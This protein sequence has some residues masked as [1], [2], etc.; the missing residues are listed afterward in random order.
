LLSLIE[1]R[2]QQGVLP[3]KFFG[4][5]HSRSIPS[6]PSFVTL[7][8]LRALTTGQDVERDVQDVVGLVVGQMPLE[9]VDLRVDRADQ[10]GLAGQE[11]YGADSASGETLD[12][13]RQF[14]V[15][16]GSGHHGLVAFWSGPIH[17]ACKDSPLAFVEH[18]AVAFARFLTV[19]FSGFLG[20]SSAHSRTS[21]DWNSEDV[22]LP[23]L[24]QNLRGFS[25]VF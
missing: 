6:P 9:D 20:D 16:V 15:D 18:P 13:I 14:V 2:K 5:A 11:V 8:F 22:F 24:F 19:A 1:V 3:L 4:F 23:P 17:D 7:N 10:S 12:A 25:S 21:E